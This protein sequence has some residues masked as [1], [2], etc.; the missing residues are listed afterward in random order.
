MN[1]HHQHPLYFDH[2][3]KNARLDAE[4]G[5]HTDTGDEVG[6]PTLEILIS[7]I[8]LLRVQ[9]HH[10]NSRLMDHVRIDAARTEQ[11][12]TVMEENEAL[13]EELAELAETI[14]IYEANARSRWMRGLSN[15]EA[16]RQTTRLAALAVS[17][18]RKSSR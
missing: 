14:E 7:Q 2:D 6:W 17:F 10:L 16:A 1:T 3:G 15:A 8:I 13:R 11:I 18:F 9:N 5:S 4:L 12:A